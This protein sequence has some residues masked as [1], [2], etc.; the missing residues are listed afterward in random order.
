AS[1][2]GLA[3]ELRNRLALKGANIDRA[4]KNLRIKISGCFNSCGQHH[5]ADIG[6]YGNSKNYGGY[7]V[8]HFQ[9]ML[10]GEWAHN[11]GSYAL[12]LGA[13]PSKRVPDLV[14]ALTDHFVAER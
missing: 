3:G 10:G 13:V 14:N 6:F 12:A 7:A 4:I 5:V 9:V 2:R 1:S 8:P 11:A